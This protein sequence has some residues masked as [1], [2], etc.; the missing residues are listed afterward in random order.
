MRHCGL[1][2]TGSRHCDRAHLD[3]IFVLVN[4]ASTQ[5]AQIGVGMPKYAG[6]TH[7]VA[8]SASG[9]FSNSR[10]TCGAS[11][12]PQGSARPLTARPHSARG[13]TRAALDNVSESM[14]P[15]R[16]RRA[17]SAPASGGRGKLG[18]LSGAVRRRQSAAHNRVD[19]LTRAEFVHC[20][21]RIAVAR[22]IQTPR[23]ARTPNAGL[24][25]VADAVDE[26]MRTLRLRVERGALQN[27]QAFRHECCY[28]LEADR[29]LRAHE[30]LLRVLYA[31]YSR[32][33]IVVTATPGDDSA[34]AVQRR[35]GA[36]E[37][38]SA[39]S[40]ELLSPCQWTCLCRDL[41][42]LGEDL[43]I[44]DARLLF[45]WS[46]MREIDEDDLER[47]QQ[48]ENLPFWG[49]LEAI[50]RVAQSKALPTDEEVAAEGVEDGGDFL[51]SLQRS[52]PSRHKAYV[53]K[54]KREWWQLTRQPVAKKLAVLLSLIMRTLVH[55]LDRWERDGTFALER[56]RAFEQRQA[57]A[58]KGGGQSPRAA[59][60]RANIP[61]SAAGSNSNVGAM[62]ARDVSGS[63]LAPRD[64]IA[65][66]MA[67]PVKLCSATTSKN[68]LQG[69][70]LL[71]KEGIP[72]SGEDM[73]T[74]ESK[75]SSD[76]VGTCGTDKKYSN[77]S[78]AASSDK[79]MPLDVFKL[80]LEQQAA[81]FSAAATRIQA[82][83][84]GWMARALGKELVAS[85]VSIQAHFRGHSARHLLVSQVAKPVPRA[86]RRGSIHRQA[87]PLASRARRGSTKTTPAGKI[88]ATTSSPTVAFAK[89]STAAAAKR[90]LA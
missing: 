22:Y 9:A 37:S 69:I 88:A 43:S 34:C 35:R 65:K 82:R 84:R 4:K 25:C 89:G 38:L 58:T 83:S 66:P 19:G 11:E 5:A 48:V 77:S 39:A 55:N 51:L 12:H 31:T 16:N 33:E 78:G 79:T 8:S 57:C 1:L 80:A 28:T 60:V 3:I 32:G 56:E 72:A 15:V 71:C 87:V 45:V 42:L 29:A 6:K 20:L 54:H 14:P 76:M 10:G 27:S 49:F 53:R 81:V 52:D 41:N 47:R 59:S 61:S 26:L 68:L 21:V 85:V 90:L 73:S 23:T 44:D 13:N 50:V 46:R 7:L 62:D 70:Q 24:S 2:I 64:A 63:E 18:S 17:S 74:Y 86:Q 30:P 75:G 40:D 67:Q 36:A